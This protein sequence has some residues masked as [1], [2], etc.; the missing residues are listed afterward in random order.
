MIRVAFLLNFDSKSWLGG[1]NLIKN[2]IY[3]IKRFSNDKIETVLI[4]RKSLSVKDAKQFTNIKLI[5]TDIFD[6]NLL[7]RII[8]KVE[9]LIFGRSKKIDNFLKKKNIKI[10]SHSNALAYNFFTGKK[11]SVKC[12][13]WIA[14]FQH[15]HYPNYF[16][17]KTRMLRNLNIIFC[18]IHSPRILLSSYDAQ[19][20][21]KKVS[22]KAYKKS[23]VS[24][25]FFES[26]KKKE[27]LSLSYLKEKFKLDNKFFYLPNQYWAHKNHIVVLKAL[28]YLKN[29]KCNYTVVST[30]HKEDHRN[31]F[32]FDKI[33]KYIKVNNLQINYKYI[34]L[35]DYSE[36]ISLMY[37][38]VAL[39]NP[40]E[41]EGRH[42]SLEQ[43]RSLGKQMILSKINIHKEQ[44]PPRTLYFNKDRSPQLAKLMKKTWSNYHPQKN[45]F[46]YYKAV[47]QNKLNLI[48]YY[49]D[50]EKV[51]TEVINFSY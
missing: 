35:V 2:L 13:S 43:A 3:C 32:Y 28:K 4:V 6:K 39:I 51:V 12:L 45:S 49:K 38:C 34:G 44:S 40:S 11:S 1:T 22:K 36:V 7:N 17:L 27:I 18:A 16:K 19:K 37:H 30:G 25:F 24:Q 26:P 50:W 47:R 10:I 20:D 46:Y 23:A 8:L 42:S 33:Q 14:D 29:N 31:S 15:L 5:K 41:F 21:L 48:K 9:I